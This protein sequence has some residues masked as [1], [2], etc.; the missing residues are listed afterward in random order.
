MEIEKDLIV[1]AEKIKENNFKNSTIMITGSTGLLGSL[2]V[3]AFVEANKK[4]NLNNK[5][6]A[7]VRNEE[8]AKNIFAEQLGEN[9]FVLV[10]NEITEN[11]NITENVDYIF[12]TACVTTSK[13][14]I[15]YPVELIKTSVNGTINVLDFAKS[16]NAKS[17]VY[18][19]S[20]EVFGVMGDYDG[21]LSENDLGKLD[22]TSVRVCYPESKRL[23]ENICKCYAEEY[24]LN[25]CTARLTQTFGAGASLEDN[26]IFAMLAKSVINGTDVVLKTTGKSAHD[27]L[28]TTDALSSVLLL[29]KKG[30]AGEVYNIGNELTNSSIYDMSN[31]VISEFNPSCKLIIENSNNV[32][33]SKD[34]IIRLDTSKIRNLGWEPKI[35]LKEMYAKLIQSYKEQM[36]NGKK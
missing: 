34:S 2:L 10:K 30:I 9:N 14:M 12:H 29:A 5:V 23:C 22:I 31:M 36:N 24:N 21:R 18:F 27:Y 11:I 20:M 26:R 7:L 25:V 6:Y 33:F 35:G 19:S 16:H 13:E 8:K 15:T 17:V 1:I 4:C 32:M 3:K 28:Y